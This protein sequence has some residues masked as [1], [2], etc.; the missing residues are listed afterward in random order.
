[1]FGSTNSSYSFEVAILD[2]GRK[3]DTAAILDYWRQNNK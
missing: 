1:M 3:V 2:E